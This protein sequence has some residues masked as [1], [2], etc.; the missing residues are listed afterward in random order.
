MCLE[1][2]TIKGKV[3]TKHDPTLVV[4]GLWSEVDDVS[5]AAIQAPH[6]LE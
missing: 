5:H 2:R 4:F 6:L 1:T 3:D